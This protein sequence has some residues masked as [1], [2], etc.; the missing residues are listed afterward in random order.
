MDRQLQLILREIPEHGDILV[1]RV[2]EEKYVLADEAH[3]VVEAVG[4]D[5]P[6][7]PAVNG[8]GAGVAVTGP[9]EEVQQG[10]LS[11]AG[12]AHQGVLLPGLQLH[13]D[14]LQHRLFQLVAESD[15]L[16][17]NGVVQLRG[18]GVA[19]AAE[20]SSWAMRACSFSA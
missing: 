8:D 18:Y 13:G 2:V 16:Q 14:V 6:E 17:G 4:G 20:C 10:A 5:L 3:D 1:Q 15:V 19:S 11:G 9:H 7:L 12:R